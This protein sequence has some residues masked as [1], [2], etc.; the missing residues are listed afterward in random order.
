M[1]VRMANGIP[2]RIQKMPGRGYIRV[3]QPEV[4]YIA[5]LFPHLCEAQVHFRAEITLKQ[6]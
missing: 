4:D 6:V 2:Q 3:S 5:S 1:V